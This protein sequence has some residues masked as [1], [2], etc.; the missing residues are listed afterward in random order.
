MNHLS[1]NEGTNGGRAYL[2]RPRRTKVDKKGKKK[3]LEPYTNEKGN[4][5]V[6]VEYTRIHTKTTRHFGMCSPAF[7]FVSLLLLMD[8]FREPG[9]LSSR[10]AQGNNTIA[11]SQERERKNKIEREERKKNGEKTLSEK[12]TKFCCGAGSY[13]AGR[14]GLSWALGRLTSVDLLS[15]P[16]TTRP[17]GRRWIR[18]RNAE[19]EGDR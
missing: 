2:E 6:Q 8:D 1:A 11:T 17:P 16:L 14:N 4:K 12:I 5:F 19:N 7:L 18:N 15:E 10:P 3:K 9:E 13:L